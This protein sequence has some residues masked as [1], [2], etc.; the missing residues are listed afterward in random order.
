M[1]KKPINKSAIRTL[2]ILC[3]AL[4][5]FVAQSYVT[6]ASTKSKNTTSLK[7]KS[8]K[9]K[10]SKKGRRH[11]RRHY[12]PEKTRAEAQEII[13]SNYYISSL[14]GYDPKMQ[15]TTL[16]G[17]P[18]DSVLMMEGE[19][20]AE[21][22]KEDDVIPNLDDMDFFRNLALAYTVGTNLNEMTEGGIRK[23]EIMNQIMDWL[24]TPYHFG[25]STGHGIDCSAFVQTIFNRCAGLYLP[26]TARD[27]YTFGDNIRMDKLE[28]GDLVFFHTYSRKFA[29]HVG[30]YLHDNLFAHSSSRYG[31]TVSSLESTYYNKHFISGKRLRQTDISRLSLNSWTNEKDE[32]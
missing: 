24:G 4:V 27:Q 22:E 20:I 23:N 18:V 28:F 21:L 32:N 30:I 13:R 9:S 25:G 1:V 11:P 6:T 7:K 16:D 12:N 15:E 19:N 17:L 14:A 5:L 31:V 10:K 3:L 8:G 29:S 26:R 2:M